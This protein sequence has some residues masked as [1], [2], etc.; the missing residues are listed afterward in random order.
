[1]KLV[2]AVV[3]VITYNRQSVVIE[4]QVYENST[5]DDLAMIGI[6]KLGIKD[7]EHNFK[8]MR[9]IIAKRI[10][11]FVKQLSRAVKSTQRQSNYK[12]MIGIDERSYLSKNNQR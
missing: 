9:D 10:E 1:M 2:L 8:V 6:R 5:Y 11:D 7:T 12:Y 4:V 3:D